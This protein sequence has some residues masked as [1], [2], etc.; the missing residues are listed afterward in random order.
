MTWIEYLLIGRAYKNKLT[1]LCKRLLLFVKL[2]SLQNPTASLK[3][4]LTSSRTHSGSSPLIPPRR[5]SLLEHVSSPHNINWTLIPTLNITILVTSITTQRSKELQLWT[6]EGAAVK[7]GYCLSLNGKPDKVCEI[8]G[9]H[10]SEYE[11]GCI[12]RCCAV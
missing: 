1:K 9:S 4:V 8:S 5:I 12:L 2:L 6:V 7:S 3:N 11:D 10:G